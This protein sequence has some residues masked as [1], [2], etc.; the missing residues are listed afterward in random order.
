MQCD[1]MQCLLNTMRLASGEIHRR[2]HVHPALRDL[3]S[4]NLTLCYYRNCLKS[5]YGFYKPY[6]SLYAGS[7][8]ELLSTFPAQRNLRWLAQDLERQ[9]VDVEALRLH[10]VAETHFEPHHVLAWLYMR[11]GSNLGGR[12]IT[13][14]LERQL[15]LRP[16]IDNRF[17]WGNG[18][19]TAENWRLFREALAVYE[20]SVDIEAAARYAGLLFARLEQW[21]S[22][23]EELKCTSNHG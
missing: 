17:F 22:Q 10:E 1:E 19:G 4:E 12:V 7:G 11:E 8:H 9:G 2:L 15:L 20:Q 14:S 23:D 18:H 5:F 3:L 13:Q 16:G 21:L 6:E